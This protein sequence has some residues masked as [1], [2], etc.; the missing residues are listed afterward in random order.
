MSVAAADDLLALAPVARLLGQLLLCELD[1]R[2]I[3][4]LQ[5]PEVDAALRA[6][7]VVPPA[8]AERE[9]LAAAFFDTLVRPRHGAPPV[10]SLWRVGQYESESTGIVRKLAAAANLELDRTVARGAPPDH[11]GSLL[12]LWCETQASVPE[13]AARIARDHLAFAE[14]ALAVPA[15]GEGFYAAVCAVTVEVVARIRAAYA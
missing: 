5:S 2:M 6:V 9:E 1:D 15:R 11:L 7:G 10:E 4:V 14:R 13:V 8:P 12:L 3:E